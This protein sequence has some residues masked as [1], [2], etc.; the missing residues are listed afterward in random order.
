L[1]DSFA[2]QPLLFPP[3][4]TLNLNLRL[5]V[6][7]CVKRRE[8]RRQLGL[9]Q[10]RDSACCSYISSQAKTDTESIELG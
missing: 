2:E 5:K 1:R 10:A 7:A 9:H 3:I 6:V 8:F 4:S